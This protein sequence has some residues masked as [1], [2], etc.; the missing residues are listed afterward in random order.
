MTIR[1]YL[2]TRH[3]NV[4]ERINTVGLAPCC[5][6]YINPLNYPLFRDGSLELADTYFV[7]DGIFMTKLLGLLLHG[8][9][10]YFPRQSFDMTSLAPEVLAYCEQRGLSIFFA[11]GSELE[12]DRFTTFING[13]YPRLKILGTSHGY[14][15]DCEIISLISKLE[16]DVVLLGLGN[17]KQEQVAVEAIRRHPAVYFSCGA[18]ISQTSNSADG[19]F[20]PDTI[21]RFHLRWLY[22]F[23]R[24]PRVLK[25]VA[26]HYPLTALRMFSD[27]RK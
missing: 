11:G 24:E 2:L 18:F 26:V 5:I 21:N 25:R 6:L 3:V 13:R 23:F 12:I 19:I 1:D 9:T 7:L 14:R 8:D 15:P 4:S 20:Y 27:S 17:G 10:R 22:R 16:P